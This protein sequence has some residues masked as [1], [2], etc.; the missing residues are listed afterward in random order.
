MLC[1]RFLVSGNVQG[2]FYRAHTQLEARRLGLRGFAKNLE[3]GDVEVIAC[4]NSNGIEALEQWLW[5][6]SP[7]SEVNNV[8]SELTNIY[9]YN[10]FKDFKTY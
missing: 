5:R 2:V 4:G 6:G 3:S 8:I 7:M 10:D 1:Q 9:S